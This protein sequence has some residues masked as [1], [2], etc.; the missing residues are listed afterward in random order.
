M[1]SLVDIKKYTE[2]YD[3][4]MDSPL[5]LLHGVYDYVEENK[6]SIK[7]PNELAEV[8]MHQMMDGDQPSYSRDA[9]D[10]LESHGINYD[11]S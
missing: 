4:L 11:L 7:I 5:E 3:E 8:T 1:R 6:Y 9:E 10:Y 2:A